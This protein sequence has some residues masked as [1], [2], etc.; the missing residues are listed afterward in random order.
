MKTAVIEHK[1]DILEQAAEMQKRIT[2]M[3]EQIQTLLRG[4]GGWT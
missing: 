4:A 2:A 3:Q 1:Q